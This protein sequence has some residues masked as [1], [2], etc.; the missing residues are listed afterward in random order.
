MLFNRFLR[1]IKASL[2][3]KETQNP[4]SGNAYNTHS[5]S[6]QSKQY[7]QYTEPTATQTQEGTYYK[8]LE[9]LPGASFEEIKASY[10]KL[11]KKYH[12]DLF[13]NH[14]EKRRYAETVTRQLNEAYAY[15]EQRFGR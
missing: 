5:Q 6:G 12:P 14:S 2:L 10:K 15:F 11:V 3:S 7:Q 1:I 8:A 13:N 4:P 9:V